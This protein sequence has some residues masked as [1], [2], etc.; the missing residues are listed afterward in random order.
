ML[1]EFPYHPDPLATGSV[2]PGEQACQCCGLSRGYVYTA[3]VYTEAELNEAICPFCIADGSAAQKFAATF[4]DSNPLIEAGV[5]EQIVEEVT[6]RTPGYTSWQ[7][8]VWLVCCSDACEFH[9][10]AR[11]E[12]LRTL[13]ADVLEEL[14]SEVEWSA[15]EWVDFVDQYEPGGDP[16]VYKFTCRHCRRARYGIDFS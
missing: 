16:A 4:S 14:L 1:P 7:Q 10:D 2:K 5:S 12:D 13:E 11:R 3:S 9:G 6:T 15:T 8:E